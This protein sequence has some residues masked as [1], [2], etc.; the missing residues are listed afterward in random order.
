[1]KSQTGFTLIELV[2]V[3]V[4]LGVLAAIAVPRFV[5]PVSYTHLTLLTKRIV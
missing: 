3:I 2:I 4:L 1:M 5:N